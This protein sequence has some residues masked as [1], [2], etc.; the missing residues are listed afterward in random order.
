[1]EDYVKTFIKCGLTIT[2]LNE[3]VPTDE[4]AA[5]SESIAWMQ[6]VPIFLFWELRKQIVTALVTLD[7]WR[8]YEVQKCYCNY[9]YAAVSIG[10]FRGEE[11]IYNTA[12]G[13]A[14]I[15]DQLKADDETSTNGDQ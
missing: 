12:Y 11:T 2:D 10:V 7:E 3:P 6:K 15:E 4:Q 9:L 14:N 13:Y 8:T 5:I 1:M